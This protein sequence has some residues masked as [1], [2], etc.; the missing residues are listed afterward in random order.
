MLLIK[1][2]MFF[3]TIIFALLSITN[4]YGANI[5]VSI[6]KLYFYKLTFAAAD[7]IILIVLVVSNII[8][9]YS[10]LLS[11]FMG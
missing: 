11:G 8:N 7:D 3:G 4:N 10:R 1:G 2:G 9:H 6:Y 5:F